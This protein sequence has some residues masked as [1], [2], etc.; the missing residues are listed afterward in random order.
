MKK[1]NIDVASTKC[2]VEALMPFK[3]A[4]NS[5]RFEIGSSKK[6][7]GEKLTSKAT[8]VNG[9]SQIQKAFFVKKPADFEEGSIYASFNLKAGD[10]L[11]L[12]VALESYAKDITISLS[13]DGAVVEF[14][15]PGI[16]KVPLNT[17]LTEELEPVLPFQEDMMVAQAA[18]DKKKFQQMVRMGAGLL[19]PKKRAGVTDRIAV[20]LTEGKVEMFSTD[21]NSIEKAWMDASIGFNANNL[22]MKALTEHAATLSPE[23]KKS[24]SD[25]ILQAGKEGVADIAKELKLNITS[26]D[27]SLSY[28]NFPTFCS[29]VKGEGIA[30]M[31]ISP[32]YIYVMADSVVAYFALA[33][34]ANSVCYVVDNCNAGNYPFRVEVD[35]S[36]FL[37]GLNLLET[38]G[39]LGAQK[40]KKLPTKLSVSKG[41]LITEMG[42]NK[43]STKVLSMTDDAETGFKNCFL[44]G[45]LLKS[46]ISV[47][48]GANLTLCLAENA[49]T[50]V[51]LSTGGLDCQE[52]SSK[53]I[54]L[55]IRDTSQAE[56]TT[57]AEE[58]KG[59]E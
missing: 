15:I 59:E 42:N 45:A 11:S 14:S 21:G 47:Q 30:K 36:E 26:L 31:L 12:L 55:R 13:D 10:T 53:A 1:I 40:E 3:G 38:T 51:V 28:T 5:I 34:A 58:E 16:T 39:S 29:I 48:E 20:R 33:G 37:K 52:A 50:P 56:E 54:I 44:N 32:A 43:V 2:L 8:L 9:G 4:D 6:A 41:K 46:I 24:L 57:E 25:R 35:K 19:D 7:S 17:V 22:A 18:L 23:D 27:F 49:N